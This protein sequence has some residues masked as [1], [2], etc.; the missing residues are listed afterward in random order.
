VPVV[1]IHIRDA[2]RL[3]AM[4]LGLCCATSFA[5]KASLTS[6]E[7]QTSPSSGTRKVV[8]VIF[9]YTQRS[10]DFTEKFVLYGWT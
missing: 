10:T 2:A 1:P 8:E 6:V 9:S 4:C 3:S 5:R 7:V